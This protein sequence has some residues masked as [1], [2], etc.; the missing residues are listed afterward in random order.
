MS[1]RHQTLED[2]R[3]EL[4]SLSSTLN[5]ELLDLVNANYSDFLSLGTQLRGGDERVEEVRFGLLGFQREIEGLRKSIEARKE[6]MKEA[7]AH[8][9]D[10]SGQIAL[11]RR[12][13]EINDRIGDLEQALLIGGTQVNGDHKEDEDFVDDHDNFTSD[14]G[15]TSDEE[16]VSATTGATGSTTHV[17]RRLRRHIEKY[18]VLRKYI[19]LYAPQHPFIE[20]Q[21]P[22][23]EKIRSTLRLDLENLQKQQPQE[24]KAGRDLAQ[25]ENIL[26]PSH[27]IEIP[28]RDNV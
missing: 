24:S 4:R 23:L 16:Q 12:L 6:E 8:K 15:D 26:S 5:N 18:Q 19:L 11:G 28:I 21:Q 1:S 14:D 2:L 3:E 27:S 7:V 13:I 17:M 10:L 25:L 20:A 22:R 9:R